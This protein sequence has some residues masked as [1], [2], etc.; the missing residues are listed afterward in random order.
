M[1]AAQCGDSD[2]IAALGAESVVFDSAYAVYPESI[3]EL[4]ALLCAKPPA[5]DATAADDARL[6]CASLAARLAEASQG[7]K[8]S[9]CWVTGCSAFS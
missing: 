5:Y 1:L 2:V 4:F 7:A 8:S 3:R 6:P 9:R